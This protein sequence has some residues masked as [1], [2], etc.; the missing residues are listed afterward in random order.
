MPGGLEGVAGLGVLPDAGSGGS[1][2]KIPIR[3]G[4]GRSVRS[5]PSEV[6]GARRHP[7]V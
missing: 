4:V 7:G 1:F 6:R 5:C 3:A 2:P